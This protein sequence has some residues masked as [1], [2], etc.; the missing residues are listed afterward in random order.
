MKHG[1]SL[2]I[3]PETGLPEAGFL[4]KLLPAI[5]GFAITATTG[6]PAWQVGL[7]VGAVETAR[8]G[9]LG[10]GI[11]AG[12]GAYGGA[13]MGAG[14]GT[15]GSEAIGSQATNAARGLTGDM[16]FNLADAGSSFSNALAGG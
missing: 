10:K 4:D 5:I 13:G 6:I 14:F 15:A 7:G 1:G 12:L 11:S 16:A 8:T 2:T 3:N 9:D